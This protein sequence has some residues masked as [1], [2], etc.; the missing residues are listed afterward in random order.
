MTHRMKKYFRMAATMV[1]IMI[2]CLSGAAGVLLFYFLLIVRFNAIS[3]IFQLSF[4]PGNFSYDLSL[5]PVPSL[6]RNTEA[7]EAYQV[8]YNNIFRP[9]DFCYGIQCSSI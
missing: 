6:I 5:L 7:K 8:L 4:Q 9:Y 1:M 3:I 2:W